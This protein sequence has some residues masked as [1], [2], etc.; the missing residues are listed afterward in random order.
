MNFSSVNRTISLLG[1]L[2]NTRQ[3]TVPE[4]QALVQ[5]PAFVPM[6][7]A[8][9]LP[10]A[11]PES[12]NVSSAQIEQFLQALASDR[13]VCPHQVLILRNGFVLA[14]AVFGAQEPDVWKHTFSA[15]KSI[16][17][18]AIG[19]LIDEGKL[20]YDTKVLPLLDAQASALVRLRLGE[21]TVRHLLTMTST[22]LFNEAES[23]A[24]ENWLRGCL[25]SLT[26]GTLGKTFH[27]NS[28]NTYL[29]SVLVRSVTGQGLVE[30]L[31]PR[32]FAPLG[33]ENIYWETCPMGY[34]RGGW[35]LYI[36]PEDL[37]KIGQLVLQEGRWN[38]KQLI[39]SDYLTQA[40]TPQVAT[41]TEYGA[42]DYGF[43]IWSGRNSNTFLFNG[44]LGQNV[45]G[46][47]NNQILIV[48]NAG[49]NDLFQTNAFFAL[50][51]ETFGG[52]WDR[53]LA[54]DAA[55]LRSLRRTIRH[56][57]H[58]H[59]ASFRKKRKLPTQCAALDGV[60]LTTEDPH[61]P[62]TG[63][64]PVLLQALGGNY[65]SGLTGL[66]FFIREHRFYVEYTEKEEVHT[67]AVGFDVPVVTTLYF[68]GIPY[69]VAVSGT[70]TH[71]EDRQPL[72]KLRLDF[73]ET[74]STR[75]LRLAF[76]RNDYALQQTESPNEQLLLRN[77]GLLTAGLEEKPLI[78][79]ALNML[80]LDYI[81]YRALRVFRPQLTL[82]RQSKQEN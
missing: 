17:S 55:A 53:P 20:S 74:P 60:A 76:D 62:S 49:N 8:A 56:F 66:R 48:A 26:A 36:S 77:L 32:L 11:T 52:A 81:E 35:G 23:A 37:A 58:Y 16:V 63:L 34:E 4:K 41:P 2:I 73:T 5:K 50:A 31:T 14:Q 82:K 64:L 29:L 67:F 33:I 19:L 59:R 7:A 72:L 61:A 43:Q 21:L 57:S 38:G 75:F 28:L 45:L 71:D 24:E 44:M 70:F 13:S 39:S 18:L 6:K 9:P 3:S 65:T 27:Y 25:N 1:Q 22:I 40:T 46:F 30:Y 54:P 79:P 69:R 42:F 68:H 15:C 10:R 78:G 12:Q 51:M 47:R 80:D